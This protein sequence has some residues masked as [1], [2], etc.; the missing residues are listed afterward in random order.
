MNTRDQRLQLVKNAIL[1]IEECRE[2]LLWFK[3]KWKCFN[4]IDKYR[5]IS[6]FIEVHIEDINEYLERIAACEDINEYLEPIA[7]CEDE[8]ATVYV[9][10]INEWR[11]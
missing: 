7:A 1:N 6:E 4:D 11:I 3:H 8:I 5:C 9:Y 10:M 2:D